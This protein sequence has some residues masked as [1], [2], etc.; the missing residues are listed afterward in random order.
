MHE[1]T[2]S[3]FTI[4]FN[5]ESLNPCS[6]FQCESFWRNLRDQFI[7]ISRMHNNK[8]NSSLI[9][10]DSLIQSS[11]KKEQEEIM[12]TTWLFSHFLEEPGNLTFLN[13]QFCPIPL[14][15]IWR[16][17]G[18][19]KYHPACLVASLNPDLQMNSFKFWNSQIFLELSLCFLTYLQTNYRNNCDKSFVIH[20]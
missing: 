18:S 6:V 19:C 7:R 15:R 13:C 4:T 12:N 9:I 8:E 1:E 10:S 16:A 2:L 20:W 17:T 11:S 14:R 5:S 3:R